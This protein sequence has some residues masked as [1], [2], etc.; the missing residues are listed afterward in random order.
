VICASV[1][2]KLLLAEP[3]LGRFVIVITLLPAVPSALPVP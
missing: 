2:P 3:A 1:S